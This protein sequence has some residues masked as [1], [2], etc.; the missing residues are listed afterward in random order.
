MF[1]FTNRVEYIAFVAQWKADYAHLSDVIRT[2]KRDI[3]KQSREQ[4]YTYLWHD[5][6]SAKDQAT[7]AINE[8]HA[9]KVQAAQQY[10]ESKATAEA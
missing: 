9:A 7:S 2:L 8:R 1:T 10:Q 4:G 5:L 6:K 3:K